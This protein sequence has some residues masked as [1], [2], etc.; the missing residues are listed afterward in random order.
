MLL[1]CFQLLRHV[2][3]MR[4]EVLAWLGGEGFSMLR[5]LLVLEL[6]CLSIE[7]DLKHGLALS[8]KLINLFPC[9]KY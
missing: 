9:I 8:Y 1:Q 7:N 5:V 4:I 3:E 2:V 6:C